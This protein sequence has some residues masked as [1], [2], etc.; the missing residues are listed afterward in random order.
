MDLEWI[1]H[2]LACDNN[3]FGLL[4]HREGTNESS[5]LLGGLPLGQ[6]TQ[7]LLT[8]PDRGVDDLEEELTCAWVEDE[9]GTVDGLCG[10]VALEGLQEPGEKGRKECKRFFAGLFFF[11]YTSMAAFTKL[12]TLWM[13]T[14]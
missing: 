10:E 8:R 11:N 13:V 1:E 12:L 14:R 4:L 5:H 3:L 7:T 2:T 6:L 9:D